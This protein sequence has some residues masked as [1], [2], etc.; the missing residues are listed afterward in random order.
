MQDKFEE[1]G[2]SIVRHIHQIKDVECVE[3]R[4]AVERHREQAAFEEQITIDE[5][6]RVM[7]VCRDGRAKR[8]AVV[9]DLAEGK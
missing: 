5:C 6:L 9:L 2:K 1:S 4:E 3:L 8:R 7:P